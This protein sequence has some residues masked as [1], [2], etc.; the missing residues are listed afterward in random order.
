RL[1]E[2]YLE[3]QMSAAGVRRS[4]DDIDELTALS[5]RCSRVGQAFFEARKQLR[6][7][8]LPNQIGDLF[9]PFGELLIEVRQDNFTPCLIVV[10]NCDADCF[11]VKAICAIV[12]LGQFEDQRLGGRSFKI[13]QTEQ[14]ISANGSGWVVHQTSKEANL[15]F[16]SR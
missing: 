10:A 5:A 6:R 14:D 9:I 4:G 13:T 2:Q 16:C 7:T 11:Q 3:Q 12:P 8:Q 1:G 15:L